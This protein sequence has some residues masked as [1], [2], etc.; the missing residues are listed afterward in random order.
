MNFD[1]KL[2]QIQ[3]VADFHPNSAE[4]SH[5]LKRLHLAH[6]GRIHAAILG[7]PLVK[8]CAADPMLAA[9]FGNGHPAL[10]LAQHAHDLGFGETALLH[11]NLLVHLA[12]KILLPHPLNHGERLPSVSKIW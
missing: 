5:V 1:R 4:W 8:R 7:P 11:R 3:T 6:H 12:E 2:E 10:R 9:Q